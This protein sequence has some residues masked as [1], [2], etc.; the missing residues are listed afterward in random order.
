MLKDFNEFI[1]EKVEVNVDT[2]LDFNVDFTFVPK[3]QP[4]SLV[5]IDGKFDEERLDLEFKL[6]DDN[7]IKFDGKFHIGPAD[8]HLKNWCKISD[9]DGVTYEVD[10]AYYLDEMGN[11][12]D[13]IYEIFIRDLFYKKMDIKGHKNEYTVDW[14][15]I[16]KEQ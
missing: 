8:A 15:K 9:S 14:Q 13:S 2:S 4:I 1:N 12:G 11:W 16:K 10:P 3:I 6:S 5:S 7:V